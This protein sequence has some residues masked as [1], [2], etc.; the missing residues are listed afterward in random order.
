[1]NIQ[2]HNH[3]VDPLELITVDVFCRFVKE[4]ALDSRP[5][6]LSWAALDIYLSQAA[7]HRSALVEFAGIRVP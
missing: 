6:D 4:K 7:S 2:Q 1:M 3:P 5:Q